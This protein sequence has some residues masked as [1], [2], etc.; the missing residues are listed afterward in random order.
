MGPISGTVPHSK[1]YGLRTS[2]E[3]D[4]AAFQRM[5][6]KIEYSQFSVRIIRPISNP[7][8]NCRELRHPLFSLHYESLEGR[9]D[10]G[11]SFQ[12]T[13]HGTVQKI[14]PIPNL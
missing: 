11:T 10:L 13:E 6:L 5:I 9:S 12:V 14:R 4:A 1:S 3:V 7:I 8:S 2:S